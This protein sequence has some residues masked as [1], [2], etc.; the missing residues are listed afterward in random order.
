M[1]ARLCGGPRAAHAFGRRP[2]GS[3]PFALWRPQRPAPPAPQLGCSAACVAL[4]LLTTHAHTPARPRVAAQLRACVRGDPHPR[5][6]QRRGRARVGTYVPAPA[7]PTDPRVGAPRAPDVWESRRGS[8]AR[9]A[10]RQSPRGR[11]GPAKELQPGRPFGPEGIAFSRS[12]SPVD[13]VA[14]TPCLSPLTLSKCLVFSR[15]TLS[16]TLP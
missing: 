13:H 1:L 11:L 3:G 5:R 9:P 7:V 12:K 4:Q 8:A 2:P 15:D 6:R 14:P 16:F 10:G